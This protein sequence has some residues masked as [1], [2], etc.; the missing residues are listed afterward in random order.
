MWAVRTGS[1]SQPQRLLRV[2]RARAGG[3]APRVDGGVGL[4]QIADDLVGIRR[5]GD[6]A[7][8]QALDELR[9]TRVH[10]APSSDSSPAQSP[11]STRREWRRTRRPVAVSAK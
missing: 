10:D 4:V 5:R 2:P 8:E 7:L 3:A 1:A 6:R 9:R 11:R